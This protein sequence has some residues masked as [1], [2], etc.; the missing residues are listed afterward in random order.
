MIEQDYALERQRSLERREAEAAA[1]VNSLQRILLDILEQVAGEKPAPEDDAVLAVFSSAGIETLPR[2]RLLFYPSLPAG[3]EPP[4]APFAAADALELQDGGRALA[5]LAPLAESANRSVRAGALLRIGRIQR[6][7]GK[8]D[9]AIRAYEKLGHIDGVRIGGEPVDLAARY[10]LCQILEQQGDRER[11]DR[12][13]EL[14]R[15][16]LRGERWRLSRPVY[17]LY[18]TWLHA[19]DVKREALAEAAAQ[20]WRDWPRLSD[21]SGWSRVSHLWIQDQPVFVFKHTAPG[22]MMA[23]LAQPSF[24]ERRWHGSLTD[25]RGR[26]LLGRPSSA[27]DA[28]RVPVASGVAWTLN[29]GLPPDEIA[30]AGF[31]Q[32]RWLLIGGLALVGLFAAAATYFITRT[33][34]RELALA[35]LQSDFVSAVSHEFRTPLTTIRQLTEMLK[36]RRVAQEAKREEY[37]DLLAHESERLLRLVE[38]LLDFRRMEADAVEFAFEPLDPAGLLRGVVADFQQEASAE[39]FQIELAANGDAPPIRGDRESLRRAVRNLLENAVKYSPDCRTVWVE[40]TEQTKQVAIRVRDH[41]M[42][43]PV[44]EQATV[45]DKFVRGR[46]AK[47]SNVPGT[48]LG[49]AMVRQIARSHGGR[50]EVRS[51]PGEGSTF[52]LLLPALE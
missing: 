30:A 16:D 52:T 1:A 9:A 49:L 47:S 29:A 7:A 15:K 10:A 40:L 33:V 23:L 18:S 3:G 42:G 11:L 25:D 28:I 45:F 36:K 46:A 27:P 14:L 44:S 43:I 26:V 35:R 32:R 48:G 8:Y 19:G 4:A 20:L 22:R 41:G 13:T 2:G 37:Y 39:G 38:D 31:T 51:R 12:E 17:S 50:V 6:K 21:A 24:L 34:A 5:A